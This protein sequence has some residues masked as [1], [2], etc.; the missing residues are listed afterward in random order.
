MSRKTGEKF[1][2]K[3]IKMLKTT[4]IIHS[5]G[6]SLHSGFSIFSSESFLL[7]G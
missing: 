6:E 3:L 4:K 1:N 7:K 5:I 2:E